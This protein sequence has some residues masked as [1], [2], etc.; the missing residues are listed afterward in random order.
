MYD[1]NLVAVETQ[2]MDVHVLSEPKVQGYLGLFRSLHE[3]AVSGQAALSLLKKARG[4]CL[5]G[6]ASSRAASTR[7]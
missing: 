7:C 3:M 6:P 2:H 1:T 5:V 4:R